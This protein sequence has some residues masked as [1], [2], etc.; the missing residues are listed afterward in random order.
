MEQAVR[1][2]EPLVEGRINILPDGQAN[3]VGIK[4][5]HCG[6]IMFPKALICTA[7]GK[8]GVEEVALS[9]HGKIW[10]Y[11]IV[12]VSYGSIILTPPYATAFVELEGGGYV[13]TPII[14]CELDEV[15]IGMDVE[16]ELVKTGQNEDADTVVYAFKPVVA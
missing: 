3:L 15:R 2:K 7:C 13:H 16:M 14:G 4:C 6:E 11:T 1:K 9:N 10:T 12:H 8:E 5:P